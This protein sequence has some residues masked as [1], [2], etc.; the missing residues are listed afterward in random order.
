MQSNYISQIRDEKINL[1]LGLNRNCS[2]KKVGAKDSIFTSKDLKLVNAPKRSRVIPL[3]SFSGFNE[4]D[5]F[6]ND[7]GVTREAIA[8]R[9]ERSE[10]TDD[11]HEGC[12]LDEVDRG[13]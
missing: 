3:T 6:G 2:I 8:E 10:F 12:E 13:N 4:H 7:E 9:D 1:D 5:I 11:D